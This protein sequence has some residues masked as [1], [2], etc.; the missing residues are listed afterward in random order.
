MTT[1]LDRSW[2]ILCLSKIW[3]SSNK[4]SSSYLLLVLSELTHIKQT[5]PFLSPFSL[6]ELGNKNKSDQV[7]HSKI[8]VNIVCLKEA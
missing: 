4:L 5:F 1:V 2:H 6:K 8:I 3:F 7:L